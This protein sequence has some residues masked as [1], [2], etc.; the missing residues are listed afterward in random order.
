MQRL[1]A[2]LEARETQLKVQ[3][4]EMKQRDA[5]INRLV[6]ELRRCQELLRQ[7]S[8]TVMYVLVNNIDVL[9]SILRAGICQCCGEETFTCTVEQR[10]TNKIGL[11]CLISR[12]IQ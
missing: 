8:S 7:V 5:E 1:Y 4:E 9:H 3:E 2:D 11:C 12:L 6:G 10:T